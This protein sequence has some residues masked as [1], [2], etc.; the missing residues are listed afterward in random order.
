MT[1]AANIFLSAVLF[2]VTLAAV[3]YIHFRAFPVNVVLYGALIDVAISVIISGLA[4]W[5]VIFRGNIS[6]IIFAQLLVIF[7]LLGYIFAITVPT[8]IDRSFSLYILE[9]LQQNDGGIR[10][11]AFDGAI[12]EEFMREHRL[13]DARLT[14]QLESGTIAIAGGCVTLTGR[15]QVIASMTRWYRQHML[16]Q[17]RLLMGT[18]SSDLTDP[19]R[20]PSRMSDYRCGEAH[21]P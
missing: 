7:T 8:V 16:P 12:V 1:L 18:Y 10:Q 19:F 21:M 2:V 3:N 17:H 15:G 14:E 4:G 13:S 9:K 20:E 6:S 5:Y 11:S